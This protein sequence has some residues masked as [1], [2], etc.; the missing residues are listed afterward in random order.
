MINHFHIDPGL[1]NLIPPLS[2]DEYARLEQSIIEEGCRDP[3]VVWK[4][5]AI[6]LDGHNRYE[7][8]TKHDI[9]FN[10]IEKEFQ[11]RQDVIAWIIGNQLARRNLTPE[12]RSYLI[13]KQYQEQK[14]QAVL[15][16]HKKTKWIA[17]A[18]SE[19][20]PGNSQPCI[21]CNKYRSVTQAHHIIPLKDQDITSSP[22]QRYV[23]LCPTHH[24][25]V[26]QLLD[27]KNG[28]PDWDGFTEEEK[29]GMFGVATLSFDISEEEWEQL[30]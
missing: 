27:R 11:N 3:L 8:C 12:Q 1:K 30:I 7:I 25:G 2:P 14:K 19:F 23:W 18:R 20:S 28:Y 24:A 16:Q 5:N 9:P 4:W 13:G 26:H 29:S 22:D 17:R 15:L 6:I 10:I 21:V